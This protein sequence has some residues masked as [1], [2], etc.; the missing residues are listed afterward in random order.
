V[1]VSVL[2]GCCRLLDGFQRFVACFPVGS[3]TVDS[4]TIYIGG[5][6]KVPGF[7][8]Y[9][10]LAEQFGAFGEVEHINV[11]H[12]KSIAFVR[13]RF[14]ANAEFGRVAM[15]NQNLGNGEILNVRW[16]YDDPNPI[17]KRAIERANQDAI[18]T[19]CSVLNLRGHAFEF[20]WLC[21]SCCHGC[22]GREVDP[23]WL[24]IP[25]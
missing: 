7:D 3:F 12:R 1:V 14:R 23:H 24:R 18:S 25:D 6:K 10:A 2:G 20:V 11:I 21:T 22:E 15:S 9:T 16:A 13:Y 19:L 4:R 8:V 5:I 17:T